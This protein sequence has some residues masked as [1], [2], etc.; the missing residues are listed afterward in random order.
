MSNT[1][2]RPSVFLSFLKFFL[3]FDSFSFFPPEK[4]EVLGYQIKKV[5]ITIIEKFLS[6]IYT[7][8]L[9]SFSK[10]IPYETE[11]FYI[12]KVLPFI[13]YKLIIHYTF[14]RRPGPS[15]L[16]VHGTTST[17]VPVTDRLRLRVRHFPKQ[18]CHY[19]NL[20]V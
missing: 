5:V 11:T 8:P 7:P 20:S 10:T 19:S 12:N 9:R 16:L 13:I 6:L 2:E 3:V 15:F 18:F 4:R 1:L 14:L 17:T